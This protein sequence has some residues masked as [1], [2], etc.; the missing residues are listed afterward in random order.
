MPV[1]EISEG[2]V[3]PFQRVEAGPDLYESEVED[4]LWANLEDLVGVPLF[5]VRRQASL[6]G[7]GRPDILALGPDG[8]VFVVEVKR[9]VDRSQLAQCLEYAG[10]ARR[11]NLDELAALYHRG[12]DAFFREWLDFTESQVPVVVGR[13]PKLVL[14]ARDFHDRT[15]SAL[16]FL[17]GYDLP[18]Q[19]LRVT[20]Y[21]D[22]SGRRL[23]DVQRDS[24]AN[25]Q[26]LAAPAD[27]RNQTVSTGSANRPASIAKQTYG[28]SISDLIEAGHLHADE[29]IEWP[30]PQLGETHRAMLTADGGIVLQDGRRFAS[31]SSAGT[32][33]A[34]VAT[35][36][37]WVSWRV[38]RLGNRT[39]AEIRDEF[40]KNAQT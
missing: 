11:T 31:P 5:P 12:S 34:D 13:L 17:Q 4:L 23:V 38:P 20:L 6:P 9:D 29:K 32:A 14:A 16:E 28:A 7:G 15:A 37:G 21:Q 22:S 3:V 2:E 24:G 39:L 26:P 35:L 10:W 19:L 25:G 18:V 1:F 27:I 36:N 30:R 40:L 8:N 33:A